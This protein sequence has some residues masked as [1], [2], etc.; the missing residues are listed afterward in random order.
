MSQSKKYISFWISF[1]FNL[2]IFQ[3]GS[4]Q[5]TEGNK[6]KEGKKAQEETKAQDT[7]NYQVRLSFF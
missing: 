1:L 7:R 2:L 6:A 4:G 5:S 3:M